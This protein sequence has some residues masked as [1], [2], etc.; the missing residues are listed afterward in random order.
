[1]FISVTCYLLSNTSA[2]VAEQLLAH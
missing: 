2:D 1:L